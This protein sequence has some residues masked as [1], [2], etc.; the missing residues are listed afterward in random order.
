MSEPIV[1]VE[2]LNVWYGK[3]QLFGASRRVHVLHDVSFELKRGEILGLVGESGC[4][5]STLARTILGIEKDRTGTIGLN[6]F[7]PQMVFQ[8]PY[9]SLNPYKKIGWII[10]EPLRVLKK[11]DK[12]ER[13][14]RVLD[15]LERVGLPESYVNRYPDELSGGQRQRVAIA[16]ALI[17]QPELI[18]LDEP[19]SALDVT[20]QAQILRLLID[21]KKQ[22]NLSYL[23]ISHDLNVIYQICDRVM[24]MKKGE[25][26]EC[27]S[28]E[29]VYNHPDHPYTKQLLTE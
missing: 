11:Y 4:G 3:P 27:G 13:K 23:F 6:T 26:V 8:N 29:K 19:V 5:K 9:G 10:E 7:R 28:I 21:V 25:I 15:L 20:V 24:V 2:N 16:A 18:F 17:Q 1:K 22:Y 14:K 12:K